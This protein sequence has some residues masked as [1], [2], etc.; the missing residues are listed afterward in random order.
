V[1]AG[2][3]KT[4]G[5]RKA[6]SQDF[7]MPKAFDANKFL[8]DDNELSIIGRHYVCSRAGMLEDKPKI[9]QDSFICMPRFVMN[10]ISLFGVCVGHG[11]NGHFVSEFIQ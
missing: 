4:N 3:P 6:R 11:I 2:S 8:T 10:N 1:G 7:D 5:H 9:N